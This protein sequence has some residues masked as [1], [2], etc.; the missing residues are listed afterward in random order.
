MRKH[1]KG[2]TLAELVMAMSITAVIGMSIAGVSVALSNAYADT[3]DFYKS[4]SSARSAMINIQSTI[5]NAGLVTA[6]DGDSIVLWHSDTNSDGKINISELTV[7]NFDSASNK[8]NQYTIKYPS[9]FSEKMQAALD[10]EVALAEVMRSSIISS[11]M[12]NQ[13]AESRILASKATAFKISSDIAPPLTTLVKIELT[14]TGD[15]GEDVTLRSAAS[16]RADIADYVGIAD[17]EYVLDLPDSMTDIGNG[18]GN[19]K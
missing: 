16:L 9:N 10:S 4:L 1:R 11:I 2:L 18:N 17:G 15:N 19:G 14:A 8:I 5:K 7:L 3:Q 13:Y 12:N 6:I